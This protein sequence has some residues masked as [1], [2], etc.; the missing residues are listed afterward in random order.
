M[1]VNKS[2]QLIKSNNKPNPKLS[3]IR[4]KNIIHSS[5]VIP[6]PKENDVFYKEN[7][8]LWEKDIAHLKE[9]HRILNKAKQSTSSHCN[10]IL[11]RKSNVFQSPLQVSTKALS[12]KQ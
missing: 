3:A 9:E 7:K 5:S 1:K 6:F 4:S 10:N 8:I 11:F 2:D 12:P